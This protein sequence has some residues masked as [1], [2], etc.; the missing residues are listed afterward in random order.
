MTVLDCGR[1]HWSEV[2]TE[3]K[4]DTQTSYVKMTTIKKKISGF[5]HSTN[6][7]HTYN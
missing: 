3:M 1:N 6:E 5:S 7:E 2:N 4:T